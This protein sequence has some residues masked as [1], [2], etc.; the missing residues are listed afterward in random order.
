MVSE[1]EALEIYRTAIHFDGLNI[2]NW[3]RE[4]FGKIVNKREKRN[5]R[6]R[7]AK[8]YWSSFYDPS[9]SIFLDPS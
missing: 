6:I 4:I 7:L 8:R 5:Y 1:T 9:I 3:S 2:A